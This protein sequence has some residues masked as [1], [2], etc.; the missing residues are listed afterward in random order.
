MKQAVQDTRSNITSVRGLPGFGR[1]AAL[2]ADGERSR[3]CC[4]WKPSAMPWSW[5]VVGSTPA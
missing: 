1:K 5:A 3:R 2:V 4:R